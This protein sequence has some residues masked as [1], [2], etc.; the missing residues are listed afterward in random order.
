MP[1]LALEELAQDK[2]VVQKTGTIFTSGWQRDA[3]YNLNLQSNLEI[4]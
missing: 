3:S 2:G 1:A 4:S